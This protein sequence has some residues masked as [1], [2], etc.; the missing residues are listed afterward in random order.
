MG[1][2]ERAARAEPTKPGDA[3][4]IKQKCN[5]RL[6]AWFRFRQ[7][8][9]RDVKGNDSSTL[10]L[11]QY[12]ARHPN[13]AHFTAELA[14][15]LEKERRIDIEQQEL[16]LT[17]GRLKQ[18]HCDP[19]IAV[20]ELRRD[21]ICGGDH[22]SALGGKEDV[23]IALDVTQ[24]LQGTQFRQLLEQLI[25]LSGLFI[26]DLQQLGGRPLQQFV[27]RPRRNDG[28]NV[29]FHVRLARFVQPTTLVGGISEKASR[30]E[31]QEQ[32]QAADNGKKFLQF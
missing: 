31:D 15:S 17:R 3:A 18:T 2:Q 10:V 20:L 7:R 29:R 30:Q 14:S 27:F 28:W 6:Y 8:S 32:E 9:G 19:G 24:A 12:R 25:Q 22:S 16:P 13:Q 1:T 11:R 26:D 21:H 5:W 23:R 4:P